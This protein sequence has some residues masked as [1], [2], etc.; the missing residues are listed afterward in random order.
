MYAVARISPASGNPQARRESLGSV[1]PYFFY[2]HIMHAGST[3][4]VYGMPFSPTSLTFSTVLACSNHTCR[5]AAPPNSMN[6]KRN[7]EILLFV[8]MTIKSEVKMAKKTNVV[9]YENNKPTEYLHESKSVSVLSPLLIVHVNILQTIVRSYKLC[10]SING[11][12]CQRYAPLVCVQL[13]SPLYRT[14][15]PR[16]L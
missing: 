2:L 11:S 3:C 15:L 16:S 9:D 6:V 7:T 8:Q 13:L 4:R 14:A 1:V 10:N 5:R 12:H